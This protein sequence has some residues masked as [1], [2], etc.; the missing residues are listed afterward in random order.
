[1]K[2]AVIN[3]LYYPYN[4]GGAETLIKQMVA[5]FKSQNH[6]V[7]LITSE[8]R[9]RKDK[10]KNPETNELRSYHFPSHYYNLAHWPSPRKVLWH[11]SN[12]FSF[13]KTT[14]IKKVLNQEK[15]DLVITHNLVGLGFRLPLAIKKLKIRHEHYLHDIQLLYPSGLLIWGQEKIIDSWSAKIYQ[16][17]TRAFLGSPA[18]VISPSQWLLNEHRRRGFFKDSET[19]LR[20]FRAKLPPADYSPRQ[21]EKNFLFVGQI[22]KHK[23][24]IFLIKTFLSVIETKPELKLTII[25]DGDC[26]EEAKKLAANSQQIEFTGRLESSLVKSLMQKNDC[27]I[28]PSLCYENA[29]LTIYEAQAAGLPVLA[30]RI[31]G[32]PEIIN[33]HDR[34]F[35]PGD[36]QDLQK[37]ILN[38]K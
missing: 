33:E 19:E 17:F 4:R 38:G 29:P 1:M 11:F 8:P 26:L 31:G 7:F 22:E 20:Y 18:K 5:D 23:G 13:A 9:G 37:Q 3:N 12:I 28:L 15:P 6:E 36:K 30:S 32:I 21:R 35:N 2:I 24:I 16:F 25:G 10:I 27:L 34:L 14:A